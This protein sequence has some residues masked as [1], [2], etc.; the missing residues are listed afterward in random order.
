MRDSVSFFSSIWFT[1]QLAAPLWQIL[2]N[3]GHCSDPSGLSWFLAPG[4]KDVMK[5]RL[6]DAI[7]KSH[8]FRLLSALGI[9]SDDAMSN[10]SDN[11]MPR[12]VENRA[13]LG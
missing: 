10:I 12:R 8:L 4:A 7:S 11:Y 13:C 1:L 5:S 2:V 6:H 3:R 9:K